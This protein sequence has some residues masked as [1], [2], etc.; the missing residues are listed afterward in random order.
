MSYCNINKIN[1]KARLKFSKKYFF[2]A[3]LIIQR[4]SHFQTQ[5][6]SIFQHFCKSL[7]LFNVV[8]NLTTF[9][10]LMK[11][12]KIYGDQ[13]K[14]LKIVGGGSTKLIKKNKTDRMMIDKPSHNHRK[15]VEGGF[16]LKYSLVTHNRMKLYQKCQ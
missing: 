9:R 1:L 6:R 11:C 8:I 4:L 5:F 7:F 16:L 10:S 12:Y 13:E 3:S 15:S 14:C 2:V